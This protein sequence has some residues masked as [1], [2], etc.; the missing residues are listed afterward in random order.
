MISIDIRPESECSTDRA[1][2]TKWDRR[3]CESGV[4]V[5]QFIEW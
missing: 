5:R 2:I 4:C 1:E 3:N